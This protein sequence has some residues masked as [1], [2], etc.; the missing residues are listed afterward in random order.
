MSLIHL[1]AEQIVGPGEDGP[2]PPKGRRPNRTALLIASVVVVEAVALFFVF[3][4]LRSDG[5][6][7]HASEGLLTSEAFTG[8]LAGAHFLEVG[9]VTLLEESGFPRNPGRRHSFS[10]EVYFEADAY[11]DITS[12][13][14]RNPSALNLLRR[15]LERE[16]EAWLLE[17]GAPGLAEPEIGRRLDAD[18]KD[19]LHDRLPALRYRITHVFKTDH[20]I[21]RY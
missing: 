13:A 3:E 2:T 14:R 17:I 20:S 6:P 15:V 18:L 4:V 11:R 12:V 7:G 1:E 16:I 19:R 8:Q 9:P 21:L 5:H 10:F